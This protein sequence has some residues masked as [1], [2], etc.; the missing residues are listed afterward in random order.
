MCACVRAC[1]CVGEERRRQAQSRKPTDS[2]TKGFQIPPRGKREWER[3]V[4]LDGTVSADTRR[5]THEERGRGNEN[6]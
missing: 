4:G 2:Q 6:T 1:A 5:G 3:G